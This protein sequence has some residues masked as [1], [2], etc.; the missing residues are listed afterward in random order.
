MSAAAQKDLRISILRLYYLIKKAHVQALPPK[1]R[2]FGDPFVKQEFRSHMNSSD[3]KFLKGFI[4]KWIEY[5]Q[6]ISKAKSLDQIAKPLDGKT[7]VF[8]SDE[9]KATLQKIK[10]EI[11]EKGPGQN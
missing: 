10:D 9:Q 5:Y 11:R 1:M 4:E 2:I 3:S 6:Q 8:F 7:L